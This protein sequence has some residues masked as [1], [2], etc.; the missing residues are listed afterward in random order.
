MAAIKVTFT[1]DPA[2]IRRLRDA[3]ARL[4][5]PKSQVVRQA[6]ADYHERI[7]RLSGRERL[8]L[9]RTFDRVVPRIPQRDASDVE[10]E[11]KQIRDA[12]RAAGRRTTA[13]AKE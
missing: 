11:L 1:L 12:R 6:I 2:T 9:L 4:A 5:L 8:R 13:R 7:G 3:A 10:A